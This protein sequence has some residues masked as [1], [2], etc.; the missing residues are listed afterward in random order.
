MNLIKLF[1]MQRVLDG[2]IIKEKGLEGRDLLPQKILALQV[3]LGELANEW[4]GFKF[5]SEDQKPRTREYLTEYTEQDSI[6][7]PGAIW[8]NPLL[9]EY[10]D[11]LH[12]ILS[13]GL[14]LGCENTLVGTADFFDNV[15]EAFNSVFTQVQTVANTPAFS[16]VV[17]R[18]RY[19]ILFDYFLTL[20][21]MLG[22]TWE[23][24]EQEYLRKNQINHDRQNNGY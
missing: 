5:W 11:C 22:F 1:E 10:V 20:G 24:I 4:R 16:S 8:R 9:E 18:G 3:E 7:G 17:K 19:S 14:E 15:T 23:Q 2:R 6:L 13:I 21:V 12:F